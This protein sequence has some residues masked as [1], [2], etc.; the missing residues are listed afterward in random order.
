M[1]FG[2]DRIKDCGIDLATNIPKEFILPCHNEMVYNPMVT[3][4]TTKTTTTTTT[5]Q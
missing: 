1:S 2:S 3:T 4:T 5:K